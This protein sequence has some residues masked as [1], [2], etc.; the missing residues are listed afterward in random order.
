MGRFNFKDDEIEDMVQFFY[1]KLE[2]V[3]QSSKFDNLKLNEPFD[4]KIKLLGEEHMKY[5]RE[6][7]EE[8]E[9]KLKKLNIPNYGL[10]D[11]FQNIEEE[12]ENIMMP[13]KTYLFEIPSTLEP[14]Q[15]YMETCF[16]TNCMILSVIVGRLTF[17]IPKPFKFQVLFPSHLF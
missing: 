7:Q 8:V 3:L 14:H 6:K 4:L 5:L 15:K 13:D 9:E 2:S 10:D 11:L 1:A 16:K 12:G 17:F